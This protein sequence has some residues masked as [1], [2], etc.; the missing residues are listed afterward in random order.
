ME[1]GAAY[2][3]DW[4]MVRSEHKLDG[5]PKVLLTYGVQ[6][7]LVK[8]RNF[9]CVHLHTHTCNLVNI[10]CW[11]LHWALKDAPIFCS[12]H[13]QILILVRKRQTCTYVS[14]TL[15]HSVIHVLWLQYHTTNSSVSLCFA[16]PQAPRDALCQE[17]KPMKQFQ[18]FSGLQVVPDQ[19]F[20]ICAN[21]EEQKMGMGLLLVHNP[22][23]LYNHSHYKTLR[24]WVA[25]CVMQLLIGPELG[26]MWVVHLWQWLPANPELLS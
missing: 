22:C 20:A 5:R 6:D 17:R 12:H 1:G 2:A 15:V 19:H 24:R 4:S 16:D 3:I 21:T 7:R 10:S 11:C 14:E 13:K 8:D 18:L 25:L 9:I 23:H 26:C